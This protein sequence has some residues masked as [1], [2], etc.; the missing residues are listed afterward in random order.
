MR[1]AYPKHLPGFDYI[2][3]YRYFLTFCCHGRAARFADSD[4]VDLV[5][6]QFLRAASDHSF[7]ILACC[8]MPDH[9]HLVLEGLAPDS[10]LKAFV[11]RA[12]QLS[13]YHYKRAYGEPLWQ[14]YCYEHVLREEEDTRA[15][16]AYVLE[17][18]VR[19]KLAETVHDYPF[20]HSS[21][22]SREELI[23]YVYRSG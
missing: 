13:A 8:S 23:E 14:R 9:V 10:G 5:M 6:T 7:A 15:V 11:T 17:N 20:V 22:Y 12:K 3:P 19:A 1:T 2:G 16:L 4:A 21:V 18:P